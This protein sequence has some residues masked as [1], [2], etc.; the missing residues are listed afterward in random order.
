MVSY[1]SIYNKSSNIL[2]MRAAPA[3]RTPGLLT[4]ATTKL[5][6]FGAGTPSPCTS[7]DS[8]GGSGLEGGRN[9][10]VYYSMKVQPDQEMYMTE[11][12]A[13]RIVFILQGL[14]TCTHSPR[15]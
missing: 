8:T 5:P 11:Y 4:S 9:T 15:I 10:G 1:A 14:Y 3:F 13:I 6:K 12:A 7:S 2:P